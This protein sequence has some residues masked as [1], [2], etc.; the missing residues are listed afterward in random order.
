MKYRISGPARVDLQEIWTYTYNQW[1]QAQAD[2][3]I[4]G[5]TTRFAWLAINKPI[6]QERDEITD[7]LHSYHHER[8]VVLFTETS[9]GI[10]IVRVL[11]ERMDLKGRAGDI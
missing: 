11:H 5:L 4:E 2:M 3:Y 9:T 10:C 6:W 7:R 8:H 1:G